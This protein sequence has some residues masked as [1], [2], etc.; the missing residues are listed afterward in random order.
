MLLK[1]FD[2]LKKSHRNLPTEIDMQYLKEGRDTT[3]PLFH[4]TLGTDSS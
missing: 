2:T 3:Y 4:N 1:I